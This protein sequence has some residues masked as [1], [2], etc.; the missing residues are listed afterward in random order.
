MQGITTQALSKSAKAEKKITQ[1]YKLPYS[2]TST[3][4]DVT[5]SC[6]GKNLQSLL[7]FL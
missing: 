7:P 3:G 5:L 1:N 6:A 2:V 4:P